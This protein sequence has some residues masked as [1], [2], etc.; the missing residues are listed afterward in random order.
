V[1]WQQPSIIMVTML[2]PLDCMLASAVSDAVG[3]V[4]ADGE[5]GVSEDQISAIIVPIGQRM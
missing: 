2:Y 5:C 4:E 1:P 3:I